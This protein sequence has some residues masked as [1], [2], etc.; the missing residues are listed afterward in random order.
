MVAAYALEEISNEEEACQ[1]GQACATCQAGFG[2]QHACSDTVYLFNSLLLSEC[3]RIAHAQFCQSSYMLR[4]LSDC[5]VVTPCIPGGVGSQ[6]L[7]LA[8]ASS[9]I[10]LCLWQSS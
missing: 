1:V 8:P 5:G 4:L 2:T 7:A 3:Q 9:L 6:G 10:Q